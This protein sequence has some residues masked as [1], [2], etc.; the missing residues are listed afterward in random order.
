MDKLK[1]HSRDLTLENIAKIGELYPGCVTEGRDGETGRTRLVVDFER[2]K[3]E[4]SDHIVDGDPERYRIDWPGKKEALVVANGPIA[5]T[6]RPSIPESEDFHNTKNLFI[7]GDNLEALKLLRETYLG[8]IRAIYIDPPYNT[9]SDFV[10][11]D[12]FDQGSSEYLMK[13][14]QKDDLG[15]RFL[16]NLDS[17]GKFHSDWLSMMYPRLRVARSLLSRDGMIFISIDDNEVAPLRLICDE[18]FGKQNFIE[19]FVWKKSYGG[20]PKEKY[21]VTQHEYVLMYAKSKE[22]FL[23]FSLP[24]DPKKVERYYK[25]K[26]EHFSIRGPYRLKPLE[27]T[28]SMDARPNLVYDIQLA[29]GEVVR[30]QRQWLWSKQRV[31]EGLKNNHVIVVRNNDRVTLNYKQYLRDEDGVERGEKA[32][33]VIDEIYTQHGTADLS[34][35]FPDQVLVQFPKPVLLI[36]RLIQIATS[37]SPDA[38]ILDFFAGSGTTAEACFRLPENVRKHVKFILVQIPEETPEASPARKAGFANISQIAKERIRRSGREIA[39]SEAKGDF[40][41]RVLKVDSSNM[42]D[43]FYQP[44]ASNQQDLLEAVENVKE[45]RSA[46]DLLFQVLVDWG[47]DLTLPIRSETVQGKSVFF[48]DDNAL[49]ACFDSGV[50][51]ELVKELARHEP[52]RVV[53]RDNGFASDAVKINVEQ[54]F[55]QLSPSTEVKSI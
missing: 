17:G 24:Y 12:D 46:E 37:N 1:M 35:H 11:D 31:E 43:V 38:I 16:A 29:D 36:Q 2:L 33:S 19:C 51:E 15:N 28:K 5:K 42:K 27:A 39:K 55:R 3:Q 23:P 13:T 21:A 40:G 50:S 53:F 26:D 9:G 54:I 48:V 25:G 44:D 45:G 4:L 52:L 22:E 14:L 7:E 32:F 41:F 30:P 18:I 34:K 10:Y 6:L 20:G 47:V 8:K 49:V